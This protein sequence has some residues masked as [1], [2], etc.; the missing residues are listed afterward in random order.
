MAANGFAFALCADDYG[1][2]P[3]VSRGIL[4]CARADRISAASAMVSLPDWP[5]AAR[6]WNAAMPDARSGAAP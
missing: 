3:G 2:S 6:D 1:M 5:R 4:D